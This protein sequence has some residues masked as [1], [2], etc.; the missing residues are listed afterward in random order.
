MTTALTPNTYYVA[1]TVQAALGKYSDIDRTD[2]A[3]QNFDTLDTATAYYN[4]LNASH[5]QLSDYESSKVFKLTAVL[6][7]VNGGDIVEYM[8]QRTLI[9]STMTTAALILKM[10]NELKAIGINPIGCYEKFPEIM[11]NGVMLAKTIGYEAWE[12]Q[13]VLSPK[14]MAIVKKYT[15]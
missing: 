8:K 2:R 9:P 12:N 3:W 15:V 4:Q 1:I 10:A 11:A 6:Y 13:S 5:A 14:I 7:E